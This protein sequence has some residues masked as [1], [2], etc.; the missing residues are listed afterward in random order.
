MKTLTTEQLEK[1]W[2]EFAKKKLVGK[3][4]V[5]VEYMNIGEAEEYMWY[6]LP[7]IITFDDG[8]QI[9]PMSDD[10]GNDGGSLAYYTDD[11]TLT[12]PVL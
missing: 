9:V 2:T 6:K 7:L 1:K 8:S 3:K 5:S 12:L 4:I 10:E 11:E